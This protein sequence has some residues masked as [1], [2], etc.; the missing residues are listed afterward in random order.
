MKTIFAF[1]VLVLLTS[2]GTKAQQPVIVSEDT[3]KLGR[4]YMP[5]F[6]VIIPEVA[7][8]KTLK[9]W[10]KSLQSGT[11]SR[12]IEKNGAMSIFGARLKSISENVVNVY[13][14]LTQ[15]DSA[16]DL[17]VA[18]ELSKDQYAGDQERDK[19]KSYLLNFAKELYLDLVNK[20]VQTESRNLRILE[21]E[22]NSLNR[23]QSKMEKSDRVNHQ[24][25]S[26]EKGNLIAL[27]EKNESL[28]SE[29]QKY[30]DQLRYLTLEE[31]NQM[32]PD[33]LKNLENQKKKNARE[34]KSSERKISK[35]EKIVE[36]N[37]VEIPKI[38]K[39]Q[40]IVRNQV[41]EQ[42]VLLQHYIDKL[43]IIKEY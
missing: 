7:Y 40:E 4:S 36:R 16:L 17:Q 29:I 35:A 6:S 13:S 11:K 25:I 2:G 24:V 10:K 37:Q 19:V 18:I 28:S 3:F 39:N 38:M 15:Q 43:D 34:V 27:K 33:Y 14:M 31:I 20:Q 30:I 42:Q 21:R 1:L 26:F 41:S 5:G 22:L 12:V 32:G 9:K 8:E 23:A